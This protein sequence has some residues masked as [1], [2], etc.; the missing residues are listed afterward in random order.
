MNLW[1]ESSPECHSNHPARVEQTSESFKFLIFMK[2]RENCECCPV[3][4]FIARS[5][6]CQ[7]FLFSIASIVINI[8]KAKI[9]C[10][11]YSTGIVHIT[12]EQLLGGTIDLIRSVLINPRLRAERIK[13]SKLPMSPPVRPS[14]L[15]RGDSPLSKPAQRITAADATIVI[16][17]PQIWCLAGSTKGRQSFRGK[18]HWE[19]CQRHNLSAP[20][21]IL[22]SGGSDV[23]FDSMIVERFIELSK[24]CVLK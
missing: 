24:T 17:V 20:A 8:S 14:P 18:V 3:P 21:P 23:T 6:D 7:E 19:K 13:A 11:C 1:R 9:L 22:T 2:H 16:E 10:R 15:L 12:F 5:Q 4:L